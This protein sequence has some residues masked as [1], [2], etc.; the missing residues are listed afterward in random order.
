MSALAHLTLAQLART[1]ASH[2][3]PGV[4]PN[5]VDPYSTGSVFIIVGAIMVCLMLVIASLRFY[6]KIFVLRNTTIDDYR[7]SAKILSL[8]TN[9]TLDTC[10]AV[11][12][13]TFEILAQNILMLTFGITDWDHCLLRNMLFL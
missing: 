2:S 7:C 6:T 13:S 8:E 5:F 3:P 12:V 1:P 4:I 10:A 11:V 9:R